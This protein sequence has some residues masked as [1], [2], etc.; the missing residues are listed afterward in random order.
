MLG[1]KMFVL[2]SIVFSLTFAAFFICPSVNAVRGEVTLSPSPAS[3]GSS[4]VL[5]ADGTSPLPVP[6]PWFMTAV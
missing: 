4:E 3:C 2:R 1:N 5:R 6:Q